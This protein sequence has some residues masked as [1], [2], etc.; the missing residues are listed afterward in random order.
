VAV[1]RWKN[2][3]G[4]RVL[5]ED[6]GGR[7]RSLPTAWTSV[8]SP[9]PFVTVSAGRSFFRIQDLLALVELIGRLAV[10]AS[11]CKGDSAVSV[12]ETMP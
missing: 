3:G 7:V 6:D 12:K 1:A 2:W 11:R 8:A 9:D 10:P 5:F 4:D